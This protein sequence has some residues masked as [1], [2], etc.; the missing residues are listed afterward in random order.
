MV[1]EESKEIKCPVAGC[2]HPPFKT[3]QALQSHLRYK[4]PES[5]GEQGLAREVPIVEEDFAK[6]LTKFKIKAD[7][8]YN[9][10]EN[11][12]HTGGSRVFEDPDILL[13]RLT[14]WSSDIPPAKRKNIIEQWFAERQIDISPEIQRKAGM[15]TDQIQE[16]DKKT[17]EDSE[18]RYVFDDNTRQVRMAK[19]GEKGGTLP[20]AKEL[21]K[22]AEEDAKAGIESPFMQDGEGRWV[23]NPKARVTGVELMAVQF[24]QQSQAKGEPVDPIIAMTQAAEKMKALRDGLGVGA[25]TLPAW[26]TDPAAFITMI[27]NISG[28]KEEDSALKTALAA[29][30][31]TV[32]ELKEERWHTQF[33]AQ[34]KQIQDVSGVLSRTLEAI[35]DMKKERVGRTEMD[36]IHDIASEGISL[37]KSELPGLR[38]DIREAVGSMA[39]PA[40]KTAEQREERKQQFKEAIDTDKEIEEIGKRIFFTES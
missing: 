12:S 30:Q 39:P 38:K 3:P 2:E 15:T 26:M 32:E 20:Q 23:L 6:L 7:L 13:R 33:E 35:A 31:K 21:K 17:K 9:I 11:V 10:A 22:M 1:T 37:A 28:G 18:V 24:M 19:E 8:A 16:T 4:H 34:Q 40:R 14:L 27:R 25:S 29:M 36:I 5:V